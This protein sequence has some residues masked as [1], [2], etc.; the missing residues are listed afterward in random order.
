MPFDIDVHRRRSIRLPGYDYASAGAY[1]VTLT[2]WQR[3]SIFGEV[4]DGEM[5][6]GGLGEIAAREWRRSEE[7]RAEIHLDAFMVM[8]NHLHAVILIRDV[9]A[10]G[11]APLRGPSIRDA[12]SR[13]PRSLGSLVAG[14]KSAATRRINETRNSPGIPIWQRNY[15]ERIIRDEDELNRIRQYILDNPAKWAEDPE[16]PAVAVK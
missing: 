11:R 1:F 8:P 16:N 15:Y 3:E 13:Q 12:P 9:G 4:V 7:L 10:H 2:T 6:L 5:I 14:F